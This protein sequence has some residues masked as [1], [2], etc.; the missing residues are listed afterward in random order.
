MEFIWNMGKENWENLVSDNRRKNGVKLS[1]DAG[2]YGNCY[3]GHLCADIQHTLDE[4]AWYIYVN[5]FGLGIND[6]Y[7]ETLEGKIP[8]SLLDLDF[9]V[10]V[11]C[12]TFE[13]FKKSFEKE[14]SNAINSSE[15]YIELAN[16]S[17]GNWQ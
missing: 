3:I 10:P 17:L 13:N 14:F 5:V 4:Y 11:R 12:K 8:Y 16:M 2:F 7:G 9:K 1:K 6:G 15:K